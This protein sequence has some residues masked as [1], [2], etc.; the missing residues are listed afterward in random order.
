M[1]YNCSFELSTSSSLSNDKLGSLER[2][3]TMT[4]PG[5]SSKGKMHS[6]KPCVAGAERISAMT[7]SG[8]SSIG[9]YI[10]ESRNEESLNEEARRFA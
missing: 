5:K 6:G 2:I 3:S 7:Y 10:A 1:A 4:F 8:K 9:Y